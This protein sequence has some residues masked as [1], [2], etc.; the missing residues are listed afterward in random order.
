MATAYAYAVSKGYTGTEEEFAQYI[1][2]VGQTAQA[3]AESA[4]SAARSA[5]TAGQSAESAAQSALEV[6]RAVEDVE[7][8]ATAAGESEAAAS[9]SA[10][11][12]QADALKAEGF[13]VGKQDGVDV[14]AQSEYYQNNSKYYSDRAKDIYDDA[15]EVR[16]SIPADYSQLS[17]DVD[18]LKADLSELGTRVDNIEEAEGLHRYGVSGI[19]QSARA[20]TRLWDA[21]GMTAQVGTDGDNSNVINDFDHVTPFKRRK[22]VGFWRLIDGKPVFHPQAYLGD[23]NYAE[24]GT[25]GDFVAVECPRAYYYFKDGVLGVSAHQYE[26]WRPFDI[27]CHD[28]NPDNTMP[29]YYKNAYALVLDENGHAVSLPGLRN[30]QGSYKALVD[31]ARTYDGGTLGNHVGLERFAYYFYEWALFTVE[32]ATQECQSIMQGCCSLRH[33]NDDRVHFI[34]ATHVITS[35]YYVSR[36]AGEYIAII[37]ADVDIN[38]A[39]YKATHRIL[40]IVR[41]DENGNH[42]ISGTHQLLTLEDLGAN[43]YVYDT[44]TD[45]RIAARPY[46]TGSCNGVSTPSGSPVSNSDGYHPMKYRHH[47]NAYANQYMTTMDLFNVKVGTGDSD[48]TLEWYLLLEPEKYIP[49]ATSKPDLTDLQTD[50]FTKL[51]VMT[52]HDR[53]KN[54]YI[55]SRVYSNEY[56]DIWIPGETEGGSASTYYAD[57]AYLVFSYVVRSVRFG[58][59]WSAGAYAG[60][61]FAY[62]LYAPSSGSAYYGG[63]LC[64]YQ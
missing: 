46:S 45:Y 15:V 18:D 29:F 41:C 7:A 17:Q 58:G 13:S 20:L 11:D 59:F 49:A 38:S 60:F 48:W 44:S 14:D 53:Y 5:T 30:E 55:K 63:D 56:P 50:L 24:D 47:E 35:N 21:V 4:E 16:D 27:F 61:S 64:V 28:H 22:C 8:A 39:S 37:A 43:Y 33:S 3:A 26:G 51:D 23:D 57:Y 19:G 62:A 25:M 31:A 9:D 52:P 12:A 1:A 42:D 10:D 2:N 6:S 36:V 54:G 32:F 40:S 34:D